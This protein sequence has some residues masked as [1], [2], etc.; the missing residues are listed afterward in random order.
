MRFARVAHV[1]SSPKRFVRSSIRPLRW[2]RLSAVRHGNGPCL[3]PGLTS[4]PRAVFVSPRPCPV[5]FDCRPCLSQSLMPHQKAITAEGLPIPVGVYCLLKTSEWLISP[6]LFLPRE[7][8]IQD[9][10]CSRVVGM[11]RD[12]RYPSIAS[13][14]ATIDAERTG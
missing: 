10:L 1:I 9:V 7:V 13:R 2:L 3:V 11:V 4:M 14:Q 5:L 8:A 6:Y 12:P